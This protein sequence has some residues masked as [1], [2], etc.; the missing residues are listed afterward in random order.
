MRILR[1]RA[2]APK[3]ILGFQLFLASFVSISSRLDSIEFSLDSKLI[4]WL[5]LADNTRS[6]TLR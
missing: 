4:Q 5:V 2:M 1:K 3:V 6:Q